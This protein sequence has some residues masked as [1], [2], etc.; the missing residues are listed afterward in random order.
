MFRVV[1]G[2]RW[3]QHE[4][5]LHAFAADGGEHGLHA[6]GAAIVQMQWPSTWGALALSSASCAAPCATPCAS[7]GGACQ[8]SEMHVAAN[9]TRHNAA[10]LRC[11]CM[12][13]DN[14]VEAG[15]VFSPCSG[16]RPS[17]PFA[18][19]EIARSLCRAH[20]E[21]VKRRPRSHFARKSVACK[22]K[23]SVGMVFASGVR[24]AIKTIAELGRVA[25]ARLR[26]GGEIC[27]LLDP[28]LAP[29]PLRL[30]A[31]GMTNCQGGLE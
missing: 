16:C 25:P 30:R 5:L 11:R 3:H 27:G 10:I 2:V 19:P 6:G 26:A 18:A 20:G 24:R 8:P 13:A 1:G 12:K 7:T 4:Y 28:P 9:A 23:S 15:N 14:F 22:M 31:S 17:R 29:L 21:K